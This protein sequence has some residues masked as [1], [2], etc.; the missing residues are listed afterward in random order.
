MGTFVDFDMAQGYV[1]WISMRDAK[2]TEELLD[3]L[4]QNLSFVTKKEDTIHSLIDIQGRNFQDFEKQIKNMTNNLSP[5]KVNPAYPSKIYYV[6][7]KVLSTDIIEGDTK[8]VDNIDDFLSM[9]ITGLDKI[10]E[11]PLASGVFPSG[12]VG[13]SYGFDWDDPAL[14]VTADSNFITTI[15]NISPS[16]IFPSGIL[17][18][19]I[20]PASGHIV[21]NF[22]YTIVQQD[23]NHAGFDEYLNLQV[24][25]VEILKDDAFVYFEYTGY[26][27]EDN[28]HIFS[29]DSALTIT[30]DCLFFNDAHY[31]IKT[32]EYTGGEW[33]IIFYET[34]P[35]FP[36]GTEFLLMGDRKVAYLNNDPVE[37]DSMDIIDVMNLQDPNNP[38]SE[39]IIVSPDDYR[40]DSDDDNRI[41]FDKVRSNYVSASGVVGEITYPIGYQPDTAFNSSYVAEYLYRSGNKPKYLTQKEY[42][43]D[44]GVKA[45]PLA[46]SNEE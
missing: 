23:Y 9:D 41:I 43:H 20:I 27:S 14:Y 31:Y 16:G 5:D 35:S 36:F 7:K 15:S 25:T 4:P 17:P 33:H 26:G 42:V 30:G 22:D 37:T 38:A 12:I 21:T 11:Y 39:G 40:I 6:E 1:F 3:N 18:S 19:G 28:E 45:I 44:L 24:E 34:F 8:V 2:K 13:L 29:G 32:A 10:T 46:S